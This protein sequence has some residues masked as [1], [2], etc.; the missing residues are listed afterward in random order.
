MGIRTL[1]EMLE[2][3][4][5]I[6]KDP[7]IIV[8]VI[9]GAGGS[10]CSGMDTR[11]QPQPTG[12]NGPAF[13]S[14]VDR[15]FSRLEKLRKVTIAVVE[16]YCMAGGFE[17]ALVCDFIIADEN[18]RIGDGHINLAGFVPNAGSSIRLPKQIGIRKAKEILFTG[19]LFSGK[20]AERMG[21]VTRAVSAEILEKTVENLISRLLD[22]SP[23]A[24]EFM[25]MLVNNSIE[26]NL[27]TGLLMERTAVNCV[28]STED[29]HE[30]MTAISEKR[31][32]VY[33]GK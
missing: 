33:R 5:Y 3:I 30:A 4:E 2:A 26:C 10:F 1:T 9:R 6:E 16:G 21:L 31:K 19:E 18:S 17:M 14:L 28:G 8:V 29:H 27:A 32:P 13:T 7:E 24:I 11:E 20:E 22:K 15:L 12:P 23:I 25:K